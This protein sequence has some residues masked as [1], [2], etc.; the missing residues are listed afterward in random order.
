MT[1]VKTAT[2]AIAAVACLASPLLA[3][4]HVTVDTM[5]GKIVVRAGYYGNEAGFTIDPTGRLMADGRLAVFEVP[6]EL[7]SGPL[8]GWKGGFEILLTSDYYLATGRLQGGSFQY[9]IV[10]VTPLAGGPGTLAWGAFD[11]NWDFQPT[12]ESDG[13][14]RAARSYDVGIGGHNHD[15]GYAF[16]ADGL[17]DVSFVA[18]DANGVYADADPVTIRFHVGNAPSCAFAD[19]DCSGTVDSGDVAIMLLDYGPCEGCL[20]DLDGSGTVDFG[21][22]ALALL[23]FG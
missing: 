15:Q 23:N 11:E 8:A 1:P 16:S 7:T 21:D 14:T 20:A 10:S 22:I 3:H 4:D 9:E 18:W 13:A 12:C 17:Y 19:L 5:N 6:D 2:L